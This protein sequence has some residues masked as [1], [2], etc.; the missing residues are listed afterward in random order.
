MEFSK[1]VTMKWSETY[2]CW[3]FSDGSVGWSLTRSCKFGK[4]GAM[5]RT[6]G[7]LS[8]VPNYRY[9]FRYGRRPAK[10]H[11]IVADAFLGP[12][13]ME[14]DH[15]DRNPLNN[16]KSNLRYATRSENCMNRKSV[17][18][19]VAKYGVHC[20]EDRNSYLRAYRKLNLEKVHAVEAR[21]RLKRKLRKQAS[22]N[23]MERING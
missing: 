6:F 15:I 17:E 13:N 22:E 19:S 21:C 7:A 8:G 1:N 18:D 14:V 9:L 10:V 12:S 16:S 4:K 20:S 5:Y 11:R 2:E 3:A 23:T